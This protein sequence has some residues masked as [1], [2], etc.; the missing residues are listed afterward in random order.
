MTKEIVK[1]IHA[2]A[3]RLGQ[4]GKLTGREDIVELVGLLRTPQGREFCLRNDFPNIDIWRMLDKAERL[5]R[6]G[7]HVDKGVVDVSDPRDIILVGDTQG[8]IGCT[9]GRHRIMLLHGAEAKV[10]AMG[11]S[12]V[13]VECSEGCKIEKQVFGSAI[14]L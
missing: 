7:I 4:C 5:E 10:S 1:L 3:L 6:F 9:D 8:V 11:W 13:S 12:V 14:F 2:E